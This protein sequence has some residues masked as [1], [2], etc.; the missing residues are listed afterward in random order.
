MALSG[1]RPYRSEKIWMIPLYTLWAR[2][3]EMAG[4]EAYL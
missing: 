4:P 3:L 1:F 2:L